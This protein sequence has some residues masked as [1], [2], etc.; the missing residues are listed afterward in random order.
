MFAKI[1]I[2][3]DTAAMM[4]SVLNPIIY[5]CFHLKTLKPRHKQ[6]PARSGVILMT[7]LHNRPEYS[8]CHDDSYT[9]HVTIDLNSSQ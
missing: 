9:N 2:F 4:N 1:F 8:R 5:G 7:R 3:T 6:Q